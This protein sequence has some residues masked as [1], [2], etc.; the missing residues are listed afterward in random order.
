MPAPTVLIV[1]DEEN[2]LEALKYNL[3]KESCLVLTATDGERGL[4]LARETR[5]DLII[6]D[7]MLPKLDGFEVCRILRREAN[8]PMLMLSARGD[9]VDLVVGVE[10]GADDYVTKPFSMRELLAMVKSML[11]RSSM[12]SETDPYPAGNCSKR[13]T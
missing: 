13:A 6:L 9:E 1:E 11:R 5:P 8:I 3:K 4:E 10:L 2:L 7:V 12:A